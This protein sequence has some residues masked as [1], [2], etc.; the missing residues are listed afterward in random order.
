M[1]FADMLALWRAAMPRVS[2]DGWTVVF[3]ATRPDREQNRNQSHL[4]R[5]SVDGGDPVRLTFDGS[6]NT[7]PAFSPDGRWIAFASN[8]VDDTLQIYVLPTAG[9]EARRVTAL[10]LG[11]RGPVWFPD[12]KRLLA[13][14]PVYRD[15]N[16]QA[17]I[18]RRED[19]R[20]KEGVRPRLIDSLMFRHWD[21]WTENKVNHLF[22]IAVDSGE[23]RDLTP[24][25]YPVP[26][27]S[28]SGPPDYAVSPDG[29]EVCFVSLR[30][31]DQAVST[32][33]NLW[34]VSPEGGEPRR[35][36]PWDGANA[37][38]AYSP[39]GSAIA[40]GGMRTPGYEADK[41]ELLVYE[42]KRGTVR[43]AAPDFA[44]SVG[45]PV[46]SP[47]GSRLFFAANDG[48]RT[49]IYAVPSAGGA[50]EPLTAE[51][52]DHNPVIAPDGKTVVFVR[53]TLT[54]PPG[55]FAVPAGGGEAASLASLN[56]DVLAELDLP[57]AEDFWY[58]GAKGAR[59]HGMLLRPPGFKAGKRYPVVFLIH[60]GPQSMFGLD[61]HERWNAQLF[62][63]RGWVVVMINPRGSRGY[64]QAF[65]DAIRGE[66][67][68]D[69]YQDLIRGFDHVLETF[70]FCDP[71]RTAAAGASF[72]GYMV[73][74]I[75]G[76]TDRFRCLVC[77]DGIFNTEM[78]EYA[79]DELWFT[80]WEFGG[81]P[82]ESPEEY[83]RW[84][85][86]L[87]AG[88][89]KTPMLIIHGEQDFRCVPEEGLTLFTALQRRGIESRLLTF[90]DEGHW[91]QKP[92]NREVWYDTVLGW[93]E[94][95]LEG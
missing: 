74:W 75:A 2:P 64:G 44:E 93:L 84:S 68:G 71:G 65:T 85:P 55:I 33:C 61:F 45:P 4:Y 12:G 67:G 63:A 57:P 56:A 92:R 22:V 29:S 26:P 13:V 21:V 16:D 76:Q 73:N 89:M 43:E 34:A 95:H 17:E 37:Y 90:P 94:A 52:G 70:D 23:A 15:T 39:D 6:V 59:V 7:A 77:H 49:R 91:V 46:W 28:L 87:Q 24:G 69:C 48:G 10:R 41:I 72:G 35:M 50:P 27:R 38:P 25:P 3:V 80:E 47:D 88:K 58:E 5:V 53:E 18:E 79:T 81:M 31:P 8:R 82:W 32:N 60:G 42:R 11:A 62:A 19:E 78:M 9:G 30:T 1:R 54:F 66:W 36:S 20:K 51:A 40:Y 86:H 14:S 83:R